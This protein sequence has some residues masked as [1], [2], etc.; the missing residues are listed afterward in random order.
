[1]KKMKAGFIGF[2]PQGV[3]FFETIE[4]YAKMGYKAMESGARLFSL[5]GDPTEHAKKVRAM[6]LEILGI[7]TSCQGKNDPNPK[8]LIERAKAIDVN[9]IMIMHTSASAWRFA[10]RAELPDYDE[11]MV[12]IGKMDR[13]AK[14]LAKE[15]M[16]LVFHNHDQEF[17]ACYKGIPLY[18]LMAA[19]AEEM[20]F[21]IDLAW[22]QYAGWD[23]AKL[24]TQLGD[25]VASLH[26]KDYIPGENYEYKPHKTITVPRYC[27]PGAGVVDLSA[28]FKAAVDVGVEWAIIEQDMQY[29][30]SHAESVQ[31]AYYNMKETGFVI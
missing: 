30:L 5:D 13:L 7:M 29:Q 14:A 22:V 24:I 8:E 2:V 16:S 1:M 21:E 4:S 25:R 27:A 12:E 15:G 20:K 9:R 6:G 10:D 11:I 26:V 28:C 17:I 23:P 31:V 3:D 19:H 18:W